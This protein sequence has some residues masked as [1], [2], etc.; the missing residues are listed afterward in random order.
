MPE[1]SF[2]HP[3][4]GLVRFR[5]VDPVWIR[6]GHIEFISGF[7]KADVTAVTIPQLKG[8]P[9]ANGG[10]LQFHKRGQKQLLTAFADIERLGLLRHIKTCAGA[11][12]MRLRKPTSGA[13]SKL[14]SNHS[15]GI[16]IDLNSDDGSLG[17]SV[18]PVAPVFE[19]LGFLWG[20]AFN[21]P[22]HFEV[23]T[24]IDNPK[25]G[26]Q[27]V[28]V[29]VENKASKLNVKNI[30]GELMVDLSGLKPFDLNFL[31]KSDEKVRVLG[32]AG[33]VDL[34]LRKFGDLL[35]A[36]LGRIVGLAGFHVVF[37]NERKLLDLRK[38]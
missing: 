13:L 32:S 29:S 2:N 21:D 24:F 17:S 31:P 11:F 30:D 26:V 12:N 28:A 22:M 36:P 8:I 33:S 15:F 37:D 7:D 4:F 25:P 34:P 10:K 38:S 9:G 18:A 5:T 16:A 6:G 3:L 20:K 23:E 14:P 19:S 27:D 35:F 1:G